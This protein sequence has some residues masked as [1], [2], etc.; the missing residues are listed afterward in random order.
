MDACTLA[1]PGHFVSAT[2]AHEQG[3]CLIGTYQPDSG[4]YGCLIAEPGHYVWY[5]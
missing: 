2:G 3:T 1:S 4:A 5:N